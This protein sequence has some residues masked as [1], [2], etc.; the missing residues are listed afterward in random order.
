MEEQRELW[1]RKYRKELEFE[2]FIALGKLLLESG[3]Y[4]EASFAILF[5]AAFSE[6]YSAATLELL[7]DWPESGFRNWAHT[8]IFC[9]MVLKQFFVRKI[10]KLDSFATWR[11][12]R[13]KWRRRTVP[14]AFL[15]ALKAGWPIPELLR[16]L[17]PMMM[18]P[19][20]VVQQGLGWFLREAWKRDSERAEKFLLQW[21]D[22]CPRLI[23]QY[24]TEKMAED[25]KQRFKRLPNTSRPK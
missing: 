4:E 12:S 1:L 2:D 20:K 16:F 3:K 18:D 19:E 6:Q 24:A 7:G 21:K 13:S 25:V 5:V 8:D 9:G 11:E 22:Q 17:H 23:I 10:V 14:V 15:E